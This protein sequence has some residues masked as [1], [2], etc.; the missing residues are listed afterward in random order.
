MLCKR[1]VN[2]KQAGSFVNGFISNKLN[3]SG[4]QR[5]QTSSGHSPIQLLCGWS[6]QPPASPCHFVSP[7]CPIY[8]PNSGEETRHKGGDYT[9]GV[10]TTRQRG[11]PA[12]KASMHLNNLLHQL[13][14]L[15]IWALPSHWGTMIH[16]P[17]P[18]CVVTR[19]KQDGF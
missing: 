2:K 7:V 17:L 12:G 18:A 1:N 11:D 8:S 10:T 13:T 9:R 5:N 14:H 15:H 3:V 16:S 19:T 6:A 4:N